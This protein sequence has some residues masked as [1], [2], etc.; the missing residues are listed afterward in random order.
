MKV[1]TNRTISSF[2]S[3]LKDSGLSSQDALF[4]ITTVVSFIGW[5][6]TLKYISESD[7]I[8]FRN[9]LYKAKH[10]YT[11]QK[12]PFASSPLK[13]VFFSLGV[14]SLL[15]IGSGIYLRFFKN[16]KSPYA[17]ST[18]PLRAGRTINFQG[19]LTDTI[20]NPISSPIDITYK[21]YTVPT[22]GA[23]ITTPED[24]TRICTASP[25]QDGVFNSLIGNDNGGSLPGGTLCTLEI[26]SSIFTENT[27]V[28][29]G[30]TIGSETSEMSP[31]QQIANVGYAINSETLQGMPPGSNASNVP[32]INSNGDMLIAAANPGLR[33]LASSNFTISSALA[34]TVQSAG[35]GDITLSATDGGSLRFRTY[36]SPGATQERMTILTTTGYVGIGTTAPRALLD[37]NGDAT[38][39]GSLIAGGQ[40]K[41][42]DFNAAPTNVGS[43]SLYYDNS[44]NKVY[45][46][47]STAWTEMGAGSIQYFQS[48]LGS[49]APTNITDALNIGAIASNS[50]LVHLPGT[51]NHDAWF[52]LGTGNL[53]I[54]TTAPTAKLDVAGNATASGNITMGGQ[55]QVGRFGSAPAQIGVGSIY[56]NTTSGKFQCFQ[57]AAWVDCVGSGGAP[58]W[59][60]I[61]APSGDLSLAM[62]SWKTTLTY[63][64]TTSTN[65]LFNLTDTSGNTGTGYLMNLTTAATSKLNPF[66]VS[67]AGVEAMTIDDHGNV[68]IGTTS[69]AYKLE[70][71]VADTSGISVYGG[72]GS[73]SESSYFL[74]QA[75]A[76]FGYDGVRGAA[77]VSDAAANK[78]IVFDTNSTERMRILASGNIGIGTT[79]PLAKLDVSGNLNVSSY[80]TVGASL[81]VGYTTV[82]AGPGNAIFSGNVGIGTAS[83]TQK[84]TLSQGTFLN[85]SGGTPATLG[86]IDTSNTSRDVRVSGKYAYSVDWD[87]AKITDVSNPSAPVLISSINFGTGNVDYVAGKYLYV[88]ANAIAG[89]CSGTTITG[90][91]FRIY[92]ISNP[93]A[94]TAAG[95]I[96]FGRTMQSIYI[97]GK[98]AYIGLT[99]DAGAGE[100][101]Q[102]YDI[103]NPAS[104]THIGGVNIT[105]S[106]YSIYISGKYAYIGNEWVGGTCS[107]ATIDGCELRIY[108]ISNPASPTAVGGINVE[109]ATYSVYISGK[110]VFAG[111]GV[112]AGTCSGTTL[113]GCEFRIYDISNPASPAAVSG[114]DFGVDVNSV[115]LS[116]KYVYVGTDAMDP[117]N[118]LKIIDFS[119]PATPV[120]V[121]GV[122]ISTVTYNINSVYASGKY[123]YVGISNDIAGNDFRIY[124]IPGIDAP[125]ATIGNIA[126]NTLNVTENAIVNN[127]LYVN[128][129][130][131]VGPGG[132]YVDAGEVAFDSNSSDT[133]FRFGQ[134]GTGDI[135]NVFDDTTEVFTILDGGKVGIGNTSPSDV[136]S[137]VQTS[138]T[139]STLDVLRNLAA[140]S[141]DSPLVN[142]VQDNSGDDQVALNI[143]NDGTGSGINITQAGTG[144]GLNLYSNVDATSNEPLVY[145]VA[146]N[147]G[148]DSDVLKIQNDGVG[149]GMYVANNGTGNGLWVTQGTTGT[150]TGLYLYSNVDATVSQPLVN[151]ISDNTGFDQTLFRLQQDGA[152]DIVNFFDGA[153]EVFTIEDGGLTGG[154][155]GINTAYPTQAL[156]VVQNDQW[157]ANIKITTNYNGA[158]LAK[159][160]T[161][162]TV[163]GAAVGDWESIGSLQF[164][165]VNSVG[166]EKAFSKI[167]GQVISSVN[168]SE[169]GAFN[170]QALVEGVDSELLHMRGDKTLFNGTNLDVDF[171]I[172]TAAGDGALYIDGATGYVGIGTTNPQIKLDV[173]GDIGSV[174]VGTDYHDVNNRGTTNFGRSSLNTTNGFAGMSVR[175]EQS[176]GGNAGNIY[177][178]TWG[179]NFALTRDVMFIGGSGNVGIGT[180]APSAPLHVGT[181]A[182]VSLAASYGAIGASSWATRGAAARAVSVYAPNGTVAGNAIFSVSDQR[183][184][185][186]I[187]PL[188]PDMVDAF[189]NTVNPVSFDW[190]SDQSPDSGFIAQDLIKKGFQYLTT[191]IPDPSMT[192]QT[193]ADGII[194]PAG[195]RFVVNYSSIV[196]ILTAGIQKNNLQISTTHS[197]LQ[198]SIGEIIILNSNLTG[199]SQDI[200]AVFATQS[201]ALTQNALQITQLQERVAV[202]EAGN[203]LSSSSAGLEITSPQMVTQNLTTDN[204]EITGGEFIMKNSLGSAFI[205][206]DSEGNATFSGTLRAEMI[207]ANQIDGLDT[208][209]NAV[210]LLSAKVASLEAGLIQS[211]GSAQLIQQENGL[212]LMGTTTAYTLSIIDKLTL[213]LLTIESD[214]SASGSIQ[215]AVVPLKLQKDS[216]GNLEIMGS[217]IVI[218]TLGNMVSKESITAREIKTNK[219]T[220]LDVKDATNGAVLSSSAG[221]AELA[222]GETSILVHSN[223]LTDV[224]LIFVTPE[225]TAV[226]VAAKKIDESTIKISIATP[227]SEVLKVSWWIIN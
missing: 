61:T 130:L 215:T 20:G 227:L 86:G 106:V 185:E 191:E 118:E 221:K 193:N 42:G 128:N 171:I 101:F 187:T 152:A 137:V 167:L 199:L 34:A 216:L 16:V 40:L 165:S 123:L 188:N 77:V 211:S 7:A 163:N 209:K 200:S 107:G 35:G 222:A 220:I 143:Q 55:L 218:D 24:A 10:T 21:F 31:R 174:Y 41:I 13:Y 5:L 172:D 196:P 195:A 208:L 80:A 151:I 59:S 100:D 33:S 127:N 52:N 98:Y 117:G 92:D 131:N 207:L 210:D 58:A 226:A 36:V 27:N 47:N 203:Q 67:S 213:G 214:A 159:F 125:A 164:D 217:K 23:P 29:L 115:F 103:S 68:G 198:S 109:Q 99:S 180:T 50:A 6:S 160:I 43:G 17:Y 78:H 60:A 173:I 30:V 177:F 57:G 88:G 170:F 45:F 156:E 162:R 142:F 75:R 28:Y 19:R 219:L 48:T 147:T 190:I 140:A 1:L 148:F 161:L 90:C 104:P 141:T 178:K 74:A 116:G 15:L 39:S 136:L 186:N 96:D 135:L 32:F 169:N 192:E 225:N 38:V 62:N 155:V 120:E 105:N 73:I 189:F 146:D 154:Y 119:T 51:I 194:S 93:S 37:V 76:K 63:G 133:A 85:T 121:G 179:Y 108:D 201:G 46:W 44:T 124:D 223:A 158:S 175:T 110:Y 112:K 87:G 157:K 82:P 95:G 204:I 166:T 8:R 102:I 132:L 206:F 11:K 25:D 184:K 49:L 138:A 69:P 12:A 66:H 150:A 91:E 212:T 129:G 64:A 89:T 79:N 83:A 197:L 139:G 181:S 18:A 3:N 149:A 224:S 126:T 2:V 4:R 84:L 54:G 168:G 65:N 153:N 145:L 70:V 134:K 9:D 26:P 176:T 122:D 72:T 81:A 94:P 71:A 22:G 14:L 114:L 53:G 111:T 144:S 183:L 182:S 202:L 205:R 56:Y 97:S 113:T